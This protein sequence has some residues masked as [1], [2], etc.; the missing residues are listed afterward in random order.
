MQSKAP[1]SQTQAPGSRPADRRSIAPLTYEEKRK[2]FKGMV[3]AELEAGFLRY[4][5]RVELMRYARR[6]GI[7]EFEA[8]LLVAE[9]Q[10]N[11]DDIDPVTFDSMTT[12]NNLTRPDTWSVSLRLVVAFIA[13][14][15][16]DVAII[17]W[18][19]P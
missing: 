11:V 8:T 4:S 15:C 18:L 12:L 19:F 9:A 14:M 3:V 5:K 2:I 17:Y 1:L 10:Y 16:I 13:A 6:L 7:P